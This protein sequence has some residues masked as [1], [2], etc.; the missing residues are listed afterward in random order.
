MKKLLTLACSFALLLFS[1]SDACAAKYNLK[2]QTYLP[3]SLLDLPQRFVDRVHALTNGEVKIELYSGGELVSSPNILKSVRSGMIDIGH[4][5]GF[6][7][8]EMKTGP[9]DSGLPMSWM[10]PVEAEIL[11]DRKG[12]FDLLKKEYEKAG[13]EYLGPAWSS[14]YLMLSKKPVRSIADMRSMKFRAMGATGKMLA[15]LGV[16]VA[17]VP[18]EDVYVALSTGQIDG[19]IYGSAY[20]YKE[21]KFFEAAEWLCTTPFID[22]INDCLIIN[23]KKFKAMPA[24]IQEAFRSA[25]YEARWYAYIKCTEQSLAVKEELFKGKMTSLS[26]EDQREMAKAAV[27]V[28]DDEAKRSPEMAAGVEIVK[29]FAKAMGRL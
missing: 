3:A 18:P 20:D 4:G 10:S 2:M 12:I 1:V 5:M 27:K 19:V 24:H 26:E 14:E 7:F 29:N 28:W 9:L 6:H 8:P 16:A 15:N 25:A 22:P 11:F 23:P 13:V 21:T 17:T